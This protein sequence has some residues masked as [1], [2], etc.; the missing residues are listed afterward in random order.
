MDAYPVEDINLKIDI[1]NPH[2]PEYYSSSKP[3]ADWQ[4]PNPIKFL[5]V[6]KT[7]FQFVLLSKNQALLDKAYS[8]LKEA[9]QEFGVGAKTS[10]GYG[11]FQ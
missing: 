2:Y 7:K 10:L 3:P 9:L 6:E 5:T 1:I 11:I 4:T 8:W